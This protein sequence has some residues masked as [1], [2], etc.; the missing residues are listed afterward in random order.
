MSH[1]K[2]FIAE[3]GEAREIHSLAGKICTVW[4]LDLNLRVTTQVLENT[5]ISQHF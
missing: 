2:Q 4:P 1:K 3:P 5:G